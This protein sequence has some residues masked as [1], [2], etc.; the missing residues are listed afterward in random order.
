MFEN[1]AQNLHTTRPLYNPQS[2]AIGLHKSHEHNKGARVG[3]IQK[4]SPQPIFAALKSPRS[5]LIFPILEG[6]N[7]AISLSIVLQNYSLIRA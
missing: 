2:R 3:T 7:W 5:L 6:K 4:L 1:G